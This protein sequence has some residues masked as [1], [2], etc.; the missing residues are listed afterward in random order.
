MS[1]PRARSCPGTDYAFKPRLRQGF[2]P[3][4]QKIVGTKE[5]QLVED[6]GG[7]KMIENVSLPPEDRGRHGPF[8]PDGRR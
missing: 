7:D 1:V 8:L 2:R 5:F 4:L 3:I 6:V